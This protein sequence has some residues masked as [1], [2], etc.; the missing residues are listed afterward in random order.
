LVKKIRDDPREFFIMQEFQTMRFDLA[1]RIGGCARPVLAALA[2]LAILGL[3][4]PSAFAAIDI[5]FT[6]LDVATSTTTG[7]TDL[8]TGGSSSG[9]NSNFSFTVSSSQTNVAGMMGSSTLA[10]NTI[11]MNN[12]SAT[13]DTLDITI[14]GTGFT[15]GTTGQNLFVNFSVGG[16]GGPTNT[17]TDTTTGK[18]WIDFTNTLFGTQ[19]QIDSG[20][21]IVPVA[22]S[23]V[24]AAYTSGTSG[25]QTINEAS[26]APPFALTQELAITLGAGDLAN[27]TITT[28][29][30][31][32]SPSPEPSSLVV[33]GFGALGMIGYGLRRR[34]A[35]AA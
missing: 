17:A 22:T 23:P 8:G 28:R 13:T 1:L 10:T 31:T 11:T 14:S 35:S 19:N 6:T 30:L 15:A 20:L 12:T 33:A 24:S 4:T 29:V 5:Q 9:T 21:T 34:K 7:P 18:S 3:A 16:S 27:L 26:P 2:I 25:I 32:A